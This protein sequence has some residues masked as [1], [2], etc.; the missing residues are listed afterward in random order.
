MFFHHLVYR[1]L[2]DRGS[3]SDVNILVTLYYFPEFSEE[4]LRT[5]LLWVTLIGIFS[6]I[7]GYILCKKDVSMDVK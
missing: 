7:V 1:I 5:Q 3:I 4:V 2:K 6:L